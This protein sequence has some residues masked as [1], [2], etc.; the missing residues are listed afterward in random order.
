MDMSLA[1]SAA[2]PHLVQV[3]VALGAAS[4][5]M[6]AAWAWHLRVR[7]A[8]LVDVAWTLCVGGA[9]VLFAWLGDGPSAR[10]LLVGG[11]AALWSLRLAWHLFDGRVRGASEEGRYRRLRA[12]WGERA[13]AWF[14]VFFLGQGVLAVLLALVFLLAA[15]ATAPL[16]WFDLLG[17]LVWVGGFV[18]ESIADRQLARFVAD[19][20]NRGRTC[21]EGLWGWSR[22]PNYFFE[23]LMWIAYALLA[24]PAP[25]GWLGWL[26]PATILFLVLK[27]TGIPPTE[28]QALR[29]RGDDYRDYQRTTSPFLPLPPRRTSLA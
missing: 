9:G 17:A 19:P 26:A 29:S 6:V 11:F 16:G 13:D 15:N 7:N 23:W 14:L 22:H 28:A 3:L 1:L 12:F 5:G 20:A 10:R 2:T 27:V 4:A 21:R 18:G 24:M 8:G 25:L